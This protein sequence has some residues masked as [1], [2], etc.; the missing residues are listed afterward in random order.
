MMIHGKMPR[1]CK[2]RFSNLNYNLC[3]NI[4]RDFEQT[5]TRNK[6]ISDL[7]FYSRIKARGHNES[8][9]TIFVSTIHKA[10]GRGFDNVYL[11]W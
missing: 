9:E 1:E 3:H 10:K 4:I 2:E 8:I 5:N 11:M 7:S 6:Y